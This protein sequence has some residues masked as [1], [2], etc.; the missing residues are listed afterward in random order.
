MTS[1]AS[2]NLMLGLEAEFDVEFP[3]CDAQAQRLPERVGDRARR[4]TSCRRPRHEHRRR[5]RPGLS[6]RDPADRRRGRGAERRRRRP[7]RPI[8]GRDRRRAAG[9][10]GPLGAHPRG[11]TTAAASPSRPSRRPASSWAVA[12]APARWSS[13]C[14]R[15]RSPRSSVTST[16]APWF[17]AYLRDVAREQR[18]VASVTSEIGTGGDI[19]RSIAAVQPG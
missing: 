10:A 17:E 5:S 14:T 18:L 15:S 16:G 8:P 19:G 12:V 11:A 7:Q 3:D 1:H 2:V 13:P 6:R 9:R 4:S